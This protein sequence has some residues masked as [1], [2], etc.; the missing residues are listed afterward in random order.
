[1]GALGARNNERIKYAQGRELVSL[2]E[3]DHF[4]V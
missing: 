2:A 3:G 1:M 4:A